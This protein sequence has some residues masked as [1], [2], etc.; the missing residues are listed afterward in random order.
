MDGAGSTRQ[1]CTRHEFPCLASRRGANGGPHKWPEG[2]RSARK[3]EQSN[4]SPNGPQP[5][6]RLARTWLQRGHPYLKST[7]SGQPDCSPTTFSAIATTAMTAEITVQM[8]RKAM[9]PRPDPADEC[10]RISAVGAQGLN[11]VG[12]GP[13]GWQPPAKWN[14]YLNPASGCQA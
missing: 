11:L 13:D 1:P 3:K 12:C 4:L 5:Q 6:I 7:M 8:P 10:P 14:T 2:K 9:T